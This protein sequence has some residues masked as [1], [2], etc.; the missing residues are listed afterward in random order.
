MV[1][2][3]TQ[4]QTYKVT[5]FGKLIKPYKLLNDLDLD[6]LNSLKQTSQIQG[7]Y[8]KCTIK[9][10]KIKSN[11]QIKKGREIEIKEIFKEV[12]NSYFSFSPPSPLVG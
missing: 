10:I 1:C 9:W 4:I 7:N 2:E 6:S 5:C 3:A 12:H 8:K 11:T